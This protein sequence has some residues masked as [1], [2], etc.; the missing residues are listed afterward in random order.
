M[1][2]SSTLRPMRA[3]AGMAQQQARLALRSLSV[4][5]ERGLVVVAPP[6][7]TQFRFGFE[8]LRYAATLTPTP[9]GVHCRI[10]APVGPVPFTAEDGA[11]RRAMLAIVRS[12]R[13]RT[14]ARFVIDTAQTIWLMAETAVAEVPTPESVMLELARH[15]AAA[16]PYLRLMRDLVPPPRRARR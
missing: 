7:P 11:A 13:D 3:I 10:T 5:A 16:R 8:G 2:N 9:Q 14:E 12:C 6:P 1:E 4:D 15:L